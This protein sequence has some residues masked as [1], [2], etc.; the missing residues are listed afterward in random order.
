MTA[1]S[2]DMPVI[3]GPTEATALG[4]IILQFIALGDIADV[5]A[6]R[7]IIKA[8]ENLKEYKPVNSAEFEEAY[9]KFLNVIKQ[10]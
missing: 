6:G 7:E 4:N 10:M 8:H 1:D 9:Q 3:A 2:L 5:D